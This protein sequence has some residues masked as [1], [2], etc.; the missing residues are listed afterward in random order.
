MITRKEFDQI[1]TPFINKT[2]E[3]VAIALEDADMEDTDINHV[4]LVGGGT[5]TPLIRT[6]LESNFGKVVTSDIN[7]MEAGM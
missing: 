1:I 6:V 4:I 5:Y 7:P 2:L 3:C